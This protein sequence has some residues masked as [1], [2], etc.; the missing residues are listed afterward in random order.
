L[1]SDV[2]GF[3]HAEISIILLSSKLCVMTY[4]KPDHRLHRLHR[5]TVEEHRR[6]ISIRELAHAGAFI[7]P[8]LFPL[9]GIE[10]HRD[11]IRIRPLTNA[12]HPGQVIRVAWRKLTFGWRPYLVCPRCQSRRWYL[13]YDSL[14]AYCRACADLHYASQRQDRKARLLAKAQAIQA[15]LWRDQTGRIIRPRRMSEN[16]YRRC[17]MKLE[18]ITAAIDGGLSL[19]SPRYRR[20]RERDADGRY[21]G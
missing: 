11:H 10:C 6:P 12:Q 13:Y 18:Q 17:I 1:V 8:C 9:Q 3:L 5:P 20:Y 19:S 16:T 4:H 7:R 21:C 14:Q 15:Q 2:S